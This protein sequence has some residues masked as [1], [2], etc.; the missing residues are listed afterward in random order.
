MNHSLPKTV[1][2]KK[3]IITGFAF[4]LA[5]TLSAQEVKAPKP[6][7]P[8]KATIAAAIAPAP[9]MPLEVPNLPVKTGTFLL[10]PEAPVPPLP[11]NAELNVGSQSEEA[12][13]APYDEFI[14]DDYKTFLKRNPTLRALGWT[15]SVVIVKLKNGKEERYR[16]Q[17]EKSMNVAEDKYGEFPLAPPPPP[18]VIAPPPPPQIKK[19]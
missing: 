8:P 13:V 3:I 14:Y 19:L 16:L 2:M 10:P 12:P 6:P 1:I 4:C 15:E 17:D 11:P 18:K 5:F 7:S 9:P